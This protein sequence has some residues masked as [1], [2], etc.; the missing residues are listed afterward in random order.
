MAGDEIRI[1]ENGFMMIHDP[2]MVA[3][4]TA[5]ELR[6]AADTMDKVQGTVS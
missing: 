4:G 3:A 2:W 5:G 6:D 1:A